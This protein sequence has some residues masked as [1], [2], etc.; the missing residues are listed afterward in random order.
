[1]AMEST[2]NSN[3]P[4]GHMIQ[5]LGSKKSILISSLCV[6]LLCLTSLNLKSTG[7]YRQYVDNKVII[8][9]KPVYS[10]GDPQQINTIQDNKIA[11]KTVKVA[12]VKE[13]YT[14]SIAPKLRPISPMAPMAPIAPKPSNEINSTYNPLKA[15]YQTN[16]S[17]P[18][19]VDQSNYGYNVASAHPISIIPHYKPMRREFVKSYVAPLNRFANKNAFNS[20]NLAYKGR[21]PKIGR[22]ML[23]PL[24]NTNS[25]QIASIGR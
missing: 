5:F 12:K 24:Q 17:M 25:Q 3:F 18:A 1:M 9:M 10:P 15:V 23:R 22:K 8:S 2:S 21:I 19:A 4:R 16:N 13:A 11:Q 6:L 20:R 14:A 7:F